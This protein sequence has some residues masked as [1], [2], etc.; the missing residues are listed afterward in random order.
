MPKLSSHD[1]ICVCTI[2]TKTIGQFKFLLHSLPPILTPL[3]HIVLYQY[4]VK[5]LICSPYV[6]NEYVISYIGINK[7]NG[8]GGYDV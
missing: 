6:F 3:L 2:D 4:T 8:G 5:Y 7:L 1:D